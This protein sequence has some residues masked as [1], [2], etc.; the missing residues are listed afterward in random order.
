M[1]NAHEVTEDI[2]FNLISIQYHASQ[3]S[4]LYE[5]FVTDAESADH[6]EVVE[7]IEGVR[8][9]TQSGPNAVTSY[10]SS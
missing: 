3:G 6:P 9:P 2:V 5:R 7:F 8:P 10:W 1:S 4:H